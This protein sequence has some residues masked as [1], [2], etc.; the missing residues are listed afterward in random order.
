MELEIQ[1]PEDNEYISA[2]MSE[3]TARRRAEERHHAWDSETQD[4]LEEEQVLRLLSRLPMSRADIDRLDSLRERL[5]VEMYM[6]DRRS[7]TVDEIRRLGSLERAVDRA[8]VRPVDAPSPR[9]GD[10]FE[11]LL[12]EAVA[13]G[14]VPPYMRNPDANSRGQRATPGDRDRRR[15]QGPEPFT[16]VP[17]QSLRGDDR[18]CTICHDAMGVRNSDGDVE[19]PSKLPCGHIFGAICIRRW[20]AD[21]NSCPLCRQRV[22]E[23]P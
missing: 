18:N 16:P 19:D 11:V 13:E 4:R 5:F 12:A 8:E 14:Y 22:L 1:R 3:F 7:V 10:L 21:T 23:R 9:F 6:T 17:L 20:V 2:G 15:R